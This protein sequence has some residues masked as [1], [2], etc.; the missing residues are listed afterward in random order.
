MRF[1]FDSS[2]GSVISTLGWIIL[3]FHGAQSVSDL[4]DG[5]CTVAAMVQP[6]Q[7]D[8]RLELFPACM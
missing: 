3:I 4:L 2:R 7:V 8:A 1:S 5:F 6:D